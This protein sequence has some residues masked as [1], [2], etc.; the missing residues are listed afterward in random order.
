MGYFIN[1][2]VGL[3][4]DQWCSRC[5][6]FRDAL[7][8]NCPILAIHQIYNYEGAASASRFNGCAALLFYNL[9]YAFQMNNPGESTTENKCHS[10]KHKGK[11]D[12][13]PV[14]FVLNCFNG[15]LHCLY[16]R[17]KTRMKPANFWAIFCLFVFHS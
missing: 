15:V 11:P 12:R 4:Y 7:D 10:R 2:T 3:Y 16:V 5:V 9:R 8:F 17:F 14:Y 6:N 1:D 13:R